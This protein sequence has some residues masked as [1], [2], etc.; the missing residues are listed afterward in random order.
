MFRITF[1]AF[2]SLSRLFSCTG[3]NNFPHASFNEKIK[4]SVQDKTIPFSFY[5]K[6]VRLKVIGDTAQPDIVFVSLHDDETTGQK[7]VSSFLKNNNYAFV[8]IENKGQR[9]IRFSYLKRNYAFD[10]NRIFTEKG[11]HQTL[12]LYGSYSD[13]VASKIKAFASSILNKLT[14]AKTIVAMHNNSNGRYSVLSYLKGQKYFKNAA[15]VNYHNGTDPDDFFLTTSP[16]L[17]ERLKAKGFNIVL[18]DNSRVADNGS[19]SVFYRNID[20]C[21]V[22]IEAQDGHFAKQNEMLQA[23]ISVL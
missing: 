3:Q 8:R 2:F 18:Q 22:N 11:I 14:T 17:F 6:V 16:Q 21:Y 1:I 5:N 20:K 4:N 23:L 13:G 10:P 7:V 12:K 15:Q 19:L 9:L